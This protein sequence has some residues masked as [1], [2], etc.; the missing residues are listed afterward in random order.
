MLARNLVRTV[1]GGWGKPLPEHV[2]AVAR[3]HLLDAIG[4]GLA[5]AGST[6]GEP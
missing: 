1:R 5:A 3:L 4:V 6:V 2:A